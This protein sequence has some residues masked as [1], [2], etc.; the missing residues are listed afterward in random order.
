MESVPPAEAGY[1]SGISAYPAL[2]RW[3]KPISPLRGWSD[4]EEHSSSSKQSSLQRRPQRVNVVT[5]KSF[6]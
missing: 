3:A 1:A 6:I 4:A 2:T 5:N